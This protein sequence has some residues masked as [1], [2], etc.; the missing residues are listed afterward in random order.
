MSFIYFIKTLDKRSNKKSPLTQDL[1]RA[2]GQTLREKVENLQLDISQYLFSAVFSPL[3]FY[4]VFMSTEFSRKSNS[5]FKITFFVAITFLVMGYLL[6][7][8][9]SL[10]KVKRNYALGLDAEIA[11]GQ[12][13]N[14]LMH[15][16]YWVFH[17]FPAES[18][19]IDHVVIS[20]N[21]IF[22]VETKGS[23]KIDNAGKNEAGSDG[24]TLKFPGWE[25]SKP[26]EQAQAQAVWLKNWLTREIG[27]KI[28]V[29]PV[30]ALPGWFVKAS[31]QDG[32]PVINGKINE[33][34]KK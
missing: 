2:P 29:H 22:A 12:V 17:D 32:V 28:E 6:Y 33:S 10:L 27:E 11:V 4:S 30:L 18:F 15:K 7:K 24:K 9:V 13:L 3:L 34:G 1:L 8:I 31:S 23:A 20:K 5:F 21:G 26:L 19:N 14:Y 25:E 16:G